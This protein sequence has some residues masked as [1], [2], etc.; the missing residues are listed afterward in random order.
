[1]KLNKI[2]LPTNK[3]FGYF[4]S[5]IFLTISLYFLYSERFSTGYIFA[6]LALLFVIITI[7]KADLLLPLNKLWM[8]FGYLLGIIISPIVLG[9]IFFGLFTPYS[10]VMRMMGRDELRLKKTNKKSYWIIRSKSTPQTDFKQ[11]F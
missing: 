9:I 7:I 8:Y 6:S 4:F 5:G 1:M 3:K 10:L 2:Q 11:Q